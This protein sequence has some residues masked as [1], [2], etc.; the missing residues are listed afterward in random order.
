MI[1]DTYRGSP[2]LLDYFA[3]MGAIVSFTRSLASKLAEF[4]TNLPLGRVGQPDECGSCCVF[5][6][7]EDASFMTGIGRCFLHDWQSVVS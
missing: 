2:G 4:G 7:L 1:R 6:A 3:T 5:L